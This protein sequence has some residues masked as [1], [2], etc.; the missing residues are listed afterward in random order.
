MSGVSLDAFCIFYLLAFP[1]VSVTFFFHSCRVTY[2]SDVNASITTRV[3]KDV[4]SLNPAFQ[5]C[6]I[7]G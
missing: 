3:I 5:T 4:K 2:K 1:I 6:D 7:R